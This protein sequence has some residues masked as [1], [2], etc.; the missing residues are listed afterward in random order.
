MNEDKITRVRR[1]AGEI[2][3]LDPSGLTES[4]GMDK[5]QGWDSLRNLAILMEIEQQFGHRFS[6]ADLAE[7][8]TI[9]SIA[10]RL[11]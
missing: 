2:L 3:G 6:V 1:I 9:R 10:D 11:P 8:N 4:Y 5:I 7:V